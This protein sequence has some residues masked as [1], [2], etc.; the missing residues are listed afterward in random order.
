M[1]WKRDTES[2]I[3]Q[4]KYAYMTNLAAKILPAEL[5]DRIY[6]K[7]P[8]VKTKENARNVRQHLLWWKQELGHC[9]LSDLKP[10]LI[11]Q[12]RDELLS[13]LTY[14]GTIRS[15][16]T[17]VRYLASLSHAFAIAVKDW[18]WIQENP[19]MKISKPKIS[20]GRTRFLNDD[21]KERLLSAC[22]E[23]ESKGLY[24][25]V[26][27]ALSTGMRRGEIM[28]LKWSDIDPARGS[29]IFP[30]PQKMETDALSLSFGMASGSTAFK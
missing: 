28:N 12:K 8:A 13:G 7:S 4:G 5:I 15:S 3:E 21:E 2:A 24:P 14:K 16:T 19:I 1:K 9:L 25:I 20:N 22:R 10:S 17:V 23:S 18:E 30:K 6:R 11:A 29:D 27:L 26:I